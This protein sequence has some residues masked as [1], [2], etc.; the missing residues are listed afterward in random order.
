VDLQLLV[1]RVV[2]RGTVVAELMP[3]R[4]LGL[5]LAEVG[6]RHARVL[7]LLLGTRRGAIWSGEGGAR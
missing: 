2:E 4:L 6:R 3:Q 1:Q 5:G 7:L